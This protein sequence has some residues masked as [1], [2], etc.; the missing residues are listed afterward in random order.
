[1][2]IVSFVICEAQTDKQAQ[3]PKTRV[4]ILGV[5]HSSQLVAESSQP[6]MFRAFFD[7]VKPAA[8]CIERSPQEFARNDFYEFTYEQQYLIVP[9]AKK[10]GIPLLPVDWLPSSEY[11]LLAFYLPDLE[12]P[13]FLRADS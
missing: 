8:F 10:R 3:S 7:R 5:S 4:V 13:V 12:K 1:M 6:G 2:V 11:S 9:Y